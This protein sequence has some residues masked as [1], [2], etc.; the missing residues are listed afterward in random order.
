MRTFNLNRTDS[1]S[2][3]MFSMEQEH[4]KIR[5][6][7]S[8]S[9]FPLYRISFRLIFLFGE[10]CFYRT[11]YTHVSLMVQ[12]NAHDF[13]PQIRFLAGELGKLHQS[14]TAKKWYLHN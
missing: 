3:L 11:F 9:H 8:V 7:G 14:E 5:I 10:P 4:A 12:Q 13:P 1:V 2:Q 6:T